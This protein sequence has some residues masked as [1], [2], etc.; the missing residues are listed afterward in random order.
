MGNLGRRFRAGRVI[1][2]YV[3][4]VGLS[5]QAG[6]GER[7]IVCWRGGHMYIMCI[8]VYNNH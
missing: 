6:G 8:N 7:G 1:L 5:R 4:P 2:V 3:G